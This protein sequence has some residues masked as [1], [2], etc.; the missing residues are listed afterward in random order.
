MSSGL[1]Y[2]GQDEV[3]ATPVVPEYDV[4][5]NRDV[6]AQTSSADTDS[7]DGI[8]FAAD[9]RVKRTGVLWRITNKLSKYGVEERGI[10]RI[11]PEERTQKSAW[12]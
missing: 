11:M 10:E 9:D 6:N 5:K 3:T 4:E 8:H 12:G 2:N 7:H 1:A